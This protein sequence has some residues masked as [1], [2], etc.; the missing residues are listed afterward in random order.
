RGGGH[1]TNDNTPTFTGTA[2]PGST[3][4]V[5]VNGVKAGTATTDASGDWTF[6]IPANH[7]LADGNYS[8]TV[9]ATD[10]AGNTSPPSAPLNVK[11]DTHTPTT[12]PG[13]GTGG[14]SGSGTGGGSGTSGSTST[15]A[16]A[17]QP[18]PFVSVAFGPAGEVLEVVSSDGTLTQIDA[19]GA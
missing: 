17:L 18:P 4:T 13:P 12:P 19:A 15:S 6:T 11:V 5:Y 3:V 9:T 10:T 8:I 16:S 1:L 14:G 2:E 7:A